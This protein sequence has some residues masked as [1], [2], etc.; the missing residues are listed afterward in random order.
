ME[1]I[2]LL[3]PNEKVPIE[4]KDG[5]LILGSTRVIN[6]KVRLVKA[7]KSVFDIPFNADRMTMIHHI[8]AH[9]VATLKDSG[10][11]QAA[12]T[13]ADDILGDL[14][15]AFEPL[16]KYGF[17]KQDLAEILM[18]RI[19]VKEPDVLLEALREAERDRNG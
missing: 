8:F 9:D 4:A 10:A 16:E 19:Q 11:W 5:M 14:R 13:M 12:E 7:R 1:N 18:N 17:K 6:P 15:R 2:K 3:A